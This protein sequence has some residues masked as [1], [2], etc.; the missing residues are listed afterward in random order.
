MDASKGYGPGIELSCKY[1]FDWLNP[2]VRR[3]TEGRCWVHSIE[4]FEHENNSALLVN[5]NNILGSF[6]EVHQWA[7]KNG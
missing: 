3:T 7:T 4:V 6:N 2:Y 5:E 1:V